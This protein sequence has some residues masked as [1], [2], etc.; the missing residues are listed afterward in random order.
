MVYCQFFSFN[1]FTLMKKR[2]I[3]YL[4]IYHL[5]LVE[6]IKILFFFVLYVFVCNMDDVVSLA[7]AA[8]ATDNSHSTLVDM[9]LIKKGNSNILILNNV[10]MSLIKKPK[11]EDKDLV[12]EHIK[13]GRVFF[14]CIAFAITFVIII[15]Y[16]NIK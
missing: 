1:F 5:V 13:T 14:G 4:F 8:P 10:D 11:P 12:P 15:K 2:F 9:S 3:S 16:F 7:Y 6:F